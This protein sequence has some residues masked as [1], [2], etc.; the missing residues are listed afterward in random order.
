M[1][2][3]R[4]LSPL[5]NA[6][7]A[8]ARHIAVPITRLFDCV[9]LAESLDGEV[10]FKQEKLANVRLRVLAPTEVAERSDQRLVSSYEIRGSL[11]RAATDRAA[12]S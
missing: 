1:E 4:G 3:D 5:G 11:Y 7:E 10:R 12:L 9:H 2:A 8:Q 6:S